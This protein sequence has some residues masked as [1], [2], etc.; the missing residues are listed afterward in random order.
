MDNEIKKLIEEKKKAWKKW[1]ESKKETDRL[2]YK[3][4]VAK[5]KKKIRNRNGGKESYGI[6]KKQPETVLCIH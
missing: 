4:V 1:K 2:E 6:Q 5:T 3:K